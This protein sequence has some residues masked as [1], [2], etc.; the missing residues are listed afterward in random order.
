[1]GSFGAVPPN[2]D[3]TEYT[4]MSYRSYVG[5]STSYYTN[6]V[7]SYPQTLMIYDIAAL[8]TLYGAN[9][10]KNN[11]DTVYQWDPDT[12]EL[13]VNDTGQ[14][15]PIADKVYMTVW[16]GGGNDTYDFSNYTTNLTV[17][18]QPGGWTVTSAQQL[19]SLGNG[20]LPAGNIANALLYQSHS[21]SL[22]ENAVGGSGDDTFTGNAAN[23]VFQGN[24]GSDVINGAGGSDTAVYSGNVESYHYSE[25]ADGSWTV[26]D[27]RAGSPD[28][29]DTLKNIR[30]LKFAD[31]T[32]DLGPSVAVI[33]GTAA[34]DT[35]DATHTIA[36]QPTPSDSIDMVYGMAS[37]DMIKSMGGDDSLYGGDGT[38]TLYGGGGND[39]LDGG[40]GADKMFGETGDD[41]FFVDNT[42]DVVVEGANQGADAVFASVS[43]TLTANTENLTLMGASALSGTGN[44]LRNGVTGNDAA[45]SLNGLTG[46]DLLSGLGGNDRLDGGV[47]ADRMIG[48]AGHDTY[49]VDNAGDVV[50]ETNGDGTDTV[51]SSISFN[52]TDAAHV[53]GAVENLTLTGTS[54]INGTGNGLDN[55]ILG[56][57]G[58]NVLSGFGGSDT[59]N[60]GGGADQMFGGAGNDT[61]CGRQCW[62]RGQRDRW[63]WNRH[64]SVVDQLQPCRPCACHWRN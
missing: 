49:V 30:F 60:G 32:V 21:A 24:G 34:N 36:G 50:D 62:R 16:D 56:N 15:A 57:S 27:N 26:A 55:V 18:L 19:A 61:L 39:R 46:D 52:L 6:G 5:G 45:N 25:N 44:E 63:G 40:A 23:N 13:S 47:G 51:L 35:I 11:G 2:G 14:G 7:G 31:A 22:I 8:Q 9:Y 41:T 37:N 53:L 12:G 48:G 3:S 33:Y 29:V 42:G 59:L 1:M 20:H 58:N 43:Y 4:V 54:W 64:G 10:Q 28:G 17:N 38:D